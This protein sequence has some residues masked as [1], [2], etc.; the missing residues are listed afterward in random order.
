MPNPTP[1]APTFAGQN[2]LITP[3]A[4]AVNQAPP[5]TIS[6][7][8]FLLVLSGVVII[9]L[10][11][12]LPDDWLQQTIT[13][14]PGGLDVNSPLQYAV[15]KWAIPLPPPVPSVY[16]LG[17]SLTE[18]A[19]F[20]GLSSV[21]EKNSGS[22]DAGFAVNDWRPTPFPTGANAADVHGNPVSNLFQGINVDLAVRNKNATLYRVSYNITLLGKIVF[23]PGIQ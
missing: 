7:Q 14:G 21:F 18:W 13:I 22:V 9:N 1:N 12:T 16:T 5:K 15:T 10:Q 3:A 2:W 19:P 11:G 4:L 8:E 17:F 20:A 23:L 6:D